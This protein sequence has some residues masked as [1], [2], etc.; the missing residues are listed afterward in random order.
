MR[1]AI[2]RAFLLF[3]ATGRAVG[4]DLSDRFK[5]DFDSAPPAL[6]VPPAANFPR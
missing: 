5:N 2:L 6:R 1:K 4:D 3:G